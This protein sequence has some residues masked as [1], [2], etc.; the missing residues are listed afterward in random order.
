M[1]DTPEKPDSPEK[2][3]PPSGT[4]GSEDV[5]ST[6]PPSGTPE[7][8]PKK[9][10]AKKRQSRPRKKAPAKLDKAEGTQADAA[11]ETPNKDDA[12]K[13]SAFG[14]GD[15]ADAPAS[16]VPESGTE[17]A[18]D[19]SKPPE[20]KGPD[21]G[22]SEDRPADAPPPAKSS[23]R[24]W[25]GI[26]VL[27]IFLVI[28]G[29]AIWTYPWNGAPPVLDDNAAFTAIGNKL[30]DLEARVQKLESAG[31]SDPA[32]AVD[33]TPLREKLAELESQVADLAATP[34][35]VAPAPVSPQGAPPEGVSSEGNETDAPSSRLT[36]ALDLL[37]SLE[38]RVDQL[39]TTGGTEALQQRVQAVETLIAETETDMAGRLENIESGLSSAADQS[40]LSSLADRVTALETGNDAELMRAASLAMAV[41]NLSRAAAGSAPFT[42]EL[43]VVRALAPDQT[44]LTALSGYAE[45]G[46]PTVTVLQSE[47]SAFG[48]A[49][50]RADRVA[51]ATGWWD[52]L[53]AN[54]SSIITVRNTNETEGE[55]T[56]ALISRIENHLVDGQLFDA[57]NTAGKL[58]PAAREAM[59]PWLDRAQPR[60]ELEA[61]IENLNADVLAAIAAG[62]SRE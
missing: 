12:S 7:E 10:A 53:L 40:D 9:E 32:T 6:A 14:E 13:Q 34:A 36:A 46:L 55:T 45:T 41:A 18:K 25:Q 8:E 23:N 44:Q 3:T 11:G 56:S 60:G 29:V 54:L 35:S 37:A 61:A 15:K 62:G 30:N 19:E 20:P 58:S 57:L 52:S 47:F 22:M 59:A 39:D 33:L 38:A 16:A 51:G 26:A 1:P 31:P 24:A 21:T 5:S 43:A 27:V 48:R 49:A 42:Q 2:A 28:G 17:M 4:P 50:I